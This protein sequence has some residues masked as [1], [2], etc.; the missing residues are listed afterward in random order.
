MNLLELKE[1]IGH[2]GMSELAEITRGNFDDEDAESLAL[3][4]SKSMSEEKILP[5]YYSDQ[6]E[7]FN[8]VGFLSLLDIEKEIEEAVSHAPKV[9][10]ISYVQAA[11]SNA[12][13]DACIENE[14]SSLLVRKV[15]Q[16]LIP[17]TKDVA[18]EIAES[19][20]ICYPN[21]LSKTSR[22]LV[23]GHANEVPAYQAVSLIAA[24]HPNLHDD[25]WRS[26]M[27][28]SNTC[29]MSDPLSCPDAVKVSPELIRVT[30]LEI[31][32]C[33]RVEIELYSEAGRI[34]IT[35]CRLSQS[36]DITV[37][38]EFC[39]W[40]KYGSN[41]ALF[42]FI[43]TLGGETISGWERGYKPGFSFGEDSKLL[44]KGL[45]ATFGVKKSGY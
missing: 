18:K 10:P 8:T 36:T 44:D 19:L 27:T 17:I 12:Y 45:I 20:V 34:P 25:I 40:N 6:E 14:V 16:A 33:S 15:A 30:L 7:L 23:F 1:L 3:A 26:G 32:P 31:N 13:W 24:A 43:Q 28:Y 21:S 5:V 35:L 37:F 11:I 38:V 22:F 39:N 4:V 2:Q 42:D 9:L 41:E 29:K